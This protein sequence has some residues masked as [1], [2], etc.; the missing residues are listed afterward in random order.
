[1]IHF[2]TNPRSALSLRIEFGRKIECRILSC[3]S[4]EIEQRFYE[5][6]MQRK[7]ILSLYL[8]LRPQILTDPTVMNSN[9]YNLQRVNMFVLGGSGVACKFTSARNGADLL[10]FDRRIRNRDLDPKARVGPLHHCI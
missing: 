2:Q 10:R 4:I 7:T 8:S 1:M 6:V 3:C 9:E 5:R